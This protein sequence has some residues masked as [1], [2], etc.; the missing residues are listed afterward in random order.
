MQTFIDI[1]VLDGRIVEIR[2]YEEP[3]EISYRK[4]LL[5]RRN[6]LI[7]KGGGFDCMS[8]RAIEQNLDWCHRTTPLMGAMLQFRC[9]EYCNTSDRHIKVSTDYKKGRSVCIYTSDHSE[10]IRIR[11]PR[12]VRLTT[13][14]DSPSRTIELISSLVLI[15]INRRGTRRKR[16]E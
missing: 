9:A 12:T 13:R 2:V 15:N 4:D 10:S 5:I 11:T 3:I 8:R 6:V 1:Y 14:P 7:V 16:S